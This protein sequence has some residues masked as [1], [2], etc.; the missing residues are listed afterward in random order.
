MKLLAIVC[1]VL[2]LTIVNADL[3]MDKGLIYPEQTVKSDA[4][5]FPNNCANVNDASGYG[6]HFRA[7]APG[8][9]CWFY[10]NDTCQDGTGFACADHAG[11]SSFPYRNTIRSIRCKWGSC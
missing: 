1:C 2:S 10:E 8:E 11:W 3:I 6:Y 9:S 4:N 5:A 7:A